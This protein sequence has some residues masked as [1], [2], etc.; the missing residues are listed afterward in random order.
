MMP[1]DS[2]SHGQN[3]PASARIPDCLGVSPALVPRVISQVASRDVTSSGKPTLLHATE[4]LIRLAKVWPSDP[5][6]SARLSVLGVGGCPGRP[7]GRPWAVQVGT[8][9]AGLSPTTSV[10]TEHASRWLR[11]ILA[12][13]PLSNAQRKAIAVVGCISP[14]SRGELPRF[15]LL[16]VAVVIILGQWFHYS[17]LLVSDRVGAGTGAVIL[18]AFYIGHYALAFWAIRQVS[19]SQLRRA[20]VW[21]GLAGVV[22]GCWVGPVVWEYKRARGQRSKEE[23]SEPRD[24]R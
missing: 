13:Y 14:E 17:A 12:A 10:G 18:A 24:Q 1:W 11:V 2:K 5:A 8:Q 21:L 23:E 7:G 6:Y 20:T 9:S 22:L 4:S 19:R 16:Q 3:V 15:S